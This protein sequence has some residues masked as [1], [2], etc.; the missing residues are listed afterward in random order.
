MSILLKLIY[1]FDIILIRTRTDFFVEIDKLILRFI[2]D[3][4]RSRIAISIL[5]NLKKVRRLTFPDLKTYHKAM[6]GQC[7][8]GIRI[9]T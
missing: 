8:T 4:N 2:Q 9:D 6:L 7:G 5:K 3:C 1:I